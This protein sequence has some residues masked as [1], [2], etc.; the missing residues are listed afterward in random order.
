[1]C[2]PFM[3]KWSKWSEMVSTTSYQKH[4]WRQCEKCGKLKARTVFCSGVPR[5]KDVN[6]LF[7][8]C[9]KA[10]KVGE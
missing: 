6:K 10:Q 2:L 3:H 1:M 4:Q 5:E 9:N 7:K 8:W